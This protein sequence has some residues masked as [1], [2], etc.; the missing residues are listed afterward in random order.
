VSWLA[1]T[2]VQTVQDVCMRKGVGFFETHFKYSNVQLV[3][4]VKDITD[5]TL[6]NI[7]EI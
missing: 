3:D 1:S 2:E 5:D 6:Y 7:A 4:I